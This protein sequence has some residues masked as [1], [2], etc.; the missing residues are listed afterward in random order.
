MALNTVADYVA[1][2]RVLLQDQIEP[3]RYPDTDL[4]ENLNDAIMEARRIRPDLFLATFRTS[5]PTY[6]ASTQSATVDMD[7]M[8]RMTLVYYMAGQSQLNDQE[9]VDDQ[10]A[11]AF[12]SKFSGQL[13]NLQG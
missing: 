8:Y 4:V 6:S 12:L 9:D 3:F 7:P 13:M 10:R 1:R 2:S 5:L 11:I